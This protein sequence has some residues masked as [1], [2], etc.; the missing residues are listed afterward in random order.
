M[1]RGV[2]DR[3]SLVCDEDVDVGCEQTWSDRSTI[4]VMEMH[5]GLQHAGRQIR[6]KTVWLG[7]GEGP[8]TYVDNRAARRRRRSKGDDSGD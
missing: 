1:P 5:F 3:F 2:N 8:A 4:E 7:K 6:L